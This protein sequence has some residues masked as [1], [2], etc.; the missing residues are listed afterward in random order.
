MKV[1]LRTEL[2][3]VFVGFGV[4]LTSQWATAQTNA[5]GST[6]VKTSTAVIV[7][8]SSCCEAEAWPEAE[9]NIS[10]ELVALGWNVTSVESEG[11]EQER[12]RREE[13]SRLA[14]QYDAVCAIRIVRAKQEKSTVDIW[15]K[16][17]LNNKTVMKT[18]SQGEEDGED[19]AIFVAFSV[20]EVLRASLIELRLQGS[21]PNEKEEIPESVNALIGEFDVTQAKEARD[22]LFR[23]TL[24]LASGIVGGPGGPDP[25]GAM[26]LMF[27]LNPAKWLSL[28]IDGLVT[29][30]GGEINAQGTGSSF[31]IAVI[32]LSAYWN[33]F[34]FKR[35]RPSVGVAAAT[36]FFWTHGYGSENLQGVSDRGN[37][38]LIG[39]SARMQWVLSDHFGLSLDGR[40]GVLVPSIEI[41]FGESVEANFGMPMLE[42]LLGLELYL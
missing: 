32:R 4:I 30:A 26:N 21:R 31:N 17:V 5:K 11:F 18:V 37:T 19:A 41:Q 1:P 35:F 40:I 3:A 10:R 12:G 14:S 15:V 38:Y 25:M 2:I 27:N 24:T 23:P 22:P 6:A 9:R 34:T 20:V 39:G 8:M 29:F 16:D 7:G 36:V 42:C 28:G 33:I 13:L